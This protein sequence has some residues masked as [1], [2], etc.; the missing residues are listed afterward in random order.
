M[1]G[2]YGPLQL[3][4][5]QMTETQ[6]D[7]RRRPFKIAGTS[8][9]AKQR[10]RLS[11]AARSAVIQAGRGYLR[12]GGYFGRYNRGSTERKF[13]DTALAFNF[14]VTAEVPATGQIVL[15]PQNDTESGRDGRTCTIKSIQIRGSVLFAPAAAA[16]AATTG[17]LWVVL[18]TQCNGAAAAVTDVFTSANAWSSMMNLSNSS[19]FRILKRFIIPV[20]PSAGATTAY[21]ETVKPFEWFKR[22]NI[23]MQFSSTTGAIT[24]I[25]TNNVFL[26]A[27]AV[28]SDDLLQ[29]SGNARV[30]F[31]G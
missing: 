1:A 2:P 6:R 30:R 25:R 17:Y 26:I 16:T 15:I 10:F 9:R 19:R 28:N 3:A 8:T 29:F 27:G 12:T 14:D 7:F 4:M 13:F 24:E 11:K 23:P 18:D 22:C 5:R 20:N 31:V 21:N